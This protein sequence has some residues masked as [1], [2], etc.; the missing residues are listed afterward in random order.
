MGKTKFAISKVQLPAPL[1]GSPPYR[2]SI[3]TRRRMVSVGWMSGTVRGILW[4][5]RGRV[6]GWN[7]LN[8]KALLIGVVL[9]GAAVVVVTEVVVVVVVVVVATM[10]EPTVTA[11]A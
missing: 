3:A 8:W 7:R 11:A 10:T 4:R 6:L 9:I 2:V 5:G 1:V